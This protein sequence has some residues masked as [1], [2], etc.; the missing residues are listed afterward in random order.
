MIHLGKDPIDIAALRRRLDSPEDGAAVI[1]EG[2]VR[3]NSHGRKVL[4]LEYQA[5]EAMALRKM[6][7]IETLARRGFAIRD[8]AIAHRLG[9]L[10][11]SECSVAIVVTSA[12]RPAAFEACRFAIDTLKKIVP[13]WKK[14]FY[15][16]GEVW[17]E[18]SHS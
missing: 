9:V 4:R 5:Y 15:E 17:I 10:E 18:G 6:A 3:N 2:M 11:L 1:F 14:E 7:E 16:D 13:I 8:I 12:H